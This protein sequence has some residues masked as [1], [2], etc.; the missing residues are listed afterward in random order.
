MLDRLQETIA[1]VCHVSWTLRPTC[2]LY[3][4]YPKYDVV[5][6]YAVMFPLYLVKT[7]ITSPS[8]YAGCAVG[9]LIRCDMSIIWFVVFCGLFI[10]LLFCAVCQPDE[11]QCDYGTCIERRLRCN[12]RQDCPRDNSDERNCR[13]YYKNVNFVCFHAVCNICFKVS[14][15][16]FTYLTGI[17]HETNGEF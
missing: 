4:P 1:R 11:W 12:G 13:E 14:G 10:V 16:N 6:C 17:F 5:N 2:L 15:G 7:E 3:T 9:L 8:L